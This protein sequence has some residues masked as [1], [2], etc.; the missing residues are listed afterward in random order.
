MQPKHKTCPRCGALFECRMHDPQH[1][2]CAEIEL[3]E[4][5][6]ELLRT[7]WHDC[8]C[9]RCLRELADLDGSAAR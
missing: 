6:I 2:Q 3:S 7:E 4:R 5:L 8:L 1:C 9:A